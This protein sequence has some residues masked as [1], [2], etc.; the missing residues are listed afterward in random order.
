MIPQKNV[1]FA[2]DPSKAA[3]GDFI[4][5]NDSRSGLK[6]TEEVII[7]KRRDEDHDWWLHRAANM[8]RIL[9]SIAARGTDGSI[10]PGIR[11]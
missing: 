8:K 2:S 1:A 7:W 10:H 9:D 11:K 6:I 4:L 3:V 5:T